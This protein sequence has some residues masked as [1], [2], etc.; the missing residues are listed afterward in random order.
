[1]AKATTLN[2]LELHALKSANYT[3]K[4]VALLA[5]DVTSAIEQVSN[6]IK[7]DV[8]QQLIAELQGLPIFGTVDE[9]NTVKVTSLLANGTYTLKYENADGSTTAIGTIVVGDGTGNGN[10]SG[11]EVP[12]YEVDIASIGYTDNARWSTSDGTIRTGATGYTSI[13]KI[14]FTRESG[15]KMTITLSGITWTDSA[16]ATQYA[17]ILMFVG[18]SFK[19]GH[20]VPLKAFPKNYDDLGVSTVLNGDGTITITI[21][22]STN[23]YKYNGFKICG[24]G[25]GANA[26]ITYKIE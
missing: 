17:Y 26:K 15:Q 9:N 5:G 6:D 20:N 14:P 22:D 19:S 10:G 3:D 12:V 2:Q 24:Y 11:G 18:E 16:V 4:K 1:M 7:G 25:T 21:V 23:G 13:N 8:V